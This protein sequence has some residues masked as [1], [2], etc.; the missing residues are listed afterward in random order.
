MLSTV[1]ASSSLSPLSG[2]EGQKLFISGR[3][4]GLV[5]ERK[6]PRTAEMVLEA[7]ASQGSQRWGVGSGPQGQG[8]WTAEHER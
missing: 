5:N 6:Q 1:P 7:W 8:G 4:G 3:A 2:G